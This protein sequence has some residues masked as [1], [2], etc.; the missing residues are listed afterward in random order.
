[1]EVSSLAKAGVKVKSKSTSFSIDPSGSKIEEDVV[2]LFQK[3]QDYSSFS[4]KLVIDSPGEYEV[5][6]VSIKVG[7]FGESEAF[8][9]LE[10]GQKLI[11]ISSPDITSDIETEDS[12]VV[13][14]RLAKKLNDEALSSIQ[15]EVVSFYGPEE[16]LPQEKE[17]LKRVDKINLK[18]TEDLKG[19][20]VYLSK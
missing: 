1:M 11:I 3:P 13:L 5:G 7:R 14:V 15:S 12:K 2:V 4:G 17:A 9:F 10:D 18:K 8:E 20:L 16:F 19:Y 6:G